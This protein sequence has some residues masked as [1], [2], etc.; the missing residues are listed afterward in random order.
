MITSHSFSFILS[1]QRL[2]GFYC[3]CICFSPLSRLPSCKKSIKLRTTRERH[4]QL[5]VLL[6]GWQM[7]REGWCLKW[8]EKKCYERVVC[9]RLLVRRVLLVVRSFTYSI[10]VW[11]LSIDISERRY[12]WTVSEVC[13]TVVTCVL[14]LILTVACRVPIIYW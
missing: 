13:Q 11:Y 7:G 2:A 9:A 14:Y 4:T 8:R 10:P 3:C 6:R 12:A 1:V 5:L